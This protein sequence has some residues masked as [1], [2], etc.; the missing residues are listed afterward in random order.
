MKIIALYGT[1]N[2]GKST[3]LKLLIKKIIVSYPKYLNTIKDTDGNLIPLEEFICDDS[4]KHDYLALFDLDG[5]KIGI[6][7]RGDNRWCLEHDFDILGEC[8]IYFCAARSDGETHT[9]LHEQE[10]FG[11]VL[12]YRHTRVDASHPENI[13]FRRKLANDSTANLLITEINCYSTKM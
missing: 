8:E 4:A 12:Y 9:F 3:T 1:G 7:T 13:E 5:K 2:S 11:T 6:T 10:Q